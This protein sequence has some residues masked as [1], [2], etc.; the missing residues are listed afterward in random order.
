MSSPEVTLWRAVILQQFVDAVAEPRTRSEAHIKRIAQQ[1]LL[2]NS[3][4]MRIVCDLAG[5]PLPMVRMKALELA[6]AG[7][8]YTKFNLSNGPKGVFA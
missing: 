3:E 2:G 7:W 8:P 4:T 5:I 6:E 1:W